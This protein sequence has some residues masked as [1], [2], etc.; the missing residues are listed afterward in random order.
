MIDR[1]LGPFT[2]V[3]YRDWMT[4][5]RLEGP[6]LFGPLEVDPLLLRGGAIARIKGPLLDPGR[7]VCDHRVGQ[8]SPWR[9]LE[10]LIA[11]SLQK[12]AG[13][14]IARNNGRAALAA[15]PD[16]IAAIQQQSTADLLRAG[17]VTLIAMI[18]QDGPNFLLEEL[19]LLGGRIRECNGGRQHYPQRKS[20]PFEGASFR[21]PR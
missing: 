17:R 11:K 9:H 13:R 12:Q 15:F 10:L 18:Y 7:K 4:M 16:A 1:L 14:R 19:D 20:S 21:P 6:K 2:I 8:F 5:G 3:D